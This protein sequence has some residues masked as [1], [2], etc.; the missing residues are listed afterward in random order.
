MNNTFFFFRNV[1][2]LMVM[3]PYWQVQMKVSQFLSGHKV[4]HLDK[5]F[6]FYYKKSEISLPHIRISVHV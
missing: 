4:A 2:V 3:L 6:T 5:T 1:I